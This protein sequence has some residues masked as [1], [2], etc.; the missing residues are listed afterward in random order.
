MDI[1]ELYHNDRSTCSQKVRICLAE[2]GLEWENHH[3]DLTKGEHLTPEY[4]A[5]NPNGVVPAI[6]HNGECI[7]ESAVICQ[8]LDEIKP[9]PVLTP[10]DAVGRARMRAWLCFID[11]VPSMAVRIPS[12]NKVILPK[13]LRMSEEDFDDMAGKHKLRKQFFKRMG[14][15]GFSD[16]EYQ[17]AM[18]DL[19]MTFE[20]META[21]KDHGGDYLLGET[22]SIA[23]ICMVTAFQRL[24]DLHMADMFEKDFPRTTAWFHR[25]KQRPSYSAAFY[26][27]SHMELEPAES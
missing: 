4:L 22:F 6:V 3:I 1:I 27:G 14:R 23:D 20:R 17:G 10:K 19:Q 24:E 9:E 21:F 18:E 12:F 16:A 5:I 13:L 25:I 15:T 2:K 11:E 26:P 8:Y 7:I